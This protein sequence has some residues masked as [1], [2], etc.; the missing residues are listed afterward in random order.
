MLQRYI[1][2]LTVD[3]IVHLSPITFTEQKKMIAEH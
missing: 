2:A 3:T 1:G